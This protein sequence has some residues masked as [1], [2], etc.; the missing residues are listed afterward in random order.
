MRIL[1][2][3]TPEFAVP[4]LTLLQQSEHNIVAVYCQPDRPS[5]RGKKISACAV[6]RTALKH[7]LSIFQPTK[8][9]QQQSHLNELSL[10]LIVIVAYGQVLLKPL[11]TLAKYGC[12]NIHAS[13]LPRW[14]GAAPIQRA[15]QAQ[16]QQTGITI[17]QMDAGLDTGA[18]ISQ[19]TI[20]IN[21][22]NSQQLHDQLAILGAQE[23]LT[24]LSQI[25][26]V[27]KKKQNASLA[28]Y[29][30]KIQK[31]EAIID[32]KQPAQKI[33]AN[34]NAFNTWPICETAIN[35]I[36]IKILAAEL[37]NNQ[38]M[39]TSKKAGDFWI[40]HYQILVQTGQGILN[41]TQVRPV[42]KN[43]L[44]SQQFINGYRNQ[45]SI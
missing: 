17:M 33:L 22:Q 38:A 34:V 1:F 10:D 14:R 44:T 19:K 26:H 12:W 18:I 35:S 29:A 28:T 40:E 15:I 5:G 27:T 39:R 3:G 42:G 36:N 41:I 30:H 4:T 9:S 25:E 16:D 43:T 23:L 21:N 7:N 13:L 32:W 31:N 37:H 20:N 11:L 6:K 2:A 24:Q 8:I 45:L